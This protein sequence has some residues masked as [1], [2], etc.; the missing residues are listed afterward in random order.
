[1]GKINNMRPVKDYPMTIAPEL[2]EAW[3]RMRRKNDPKEIAEEL[4][5]SRAL[6]DRALKYGH[7][8]DQNVV[9]GITEYYER[10]LDNETRDGKSILKK[11]SNV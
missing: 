6:I 9:K 4:G 8:K 5:K 2:H 11:L 7:V 1:M 3:V 10:R